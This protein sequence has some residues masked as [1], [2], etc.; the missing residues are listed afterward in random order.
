MSDAEV[1]QQLIAGEFVDVC[2][3]VED[4]RSRDRKH[5]TKGLGGPRGILRF[6]MCN[7]E[8]RERGRHVG[9]SKNGKRRVYEKKKDLYGLRV[10]CGQ[11]PKTNDLSLSFSSISL[12]C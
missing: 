3:V 10:C 11:D 8:T 1:K 4:R 6:D 7:V 12:S 2:L 9:R 5:R